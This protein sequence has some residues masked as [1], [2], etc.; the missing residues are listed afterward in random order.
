MSDKKKDLLVFSL[1]SIKTN[2][3]KWDQNAITF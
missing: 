3:I 1:E 2:V